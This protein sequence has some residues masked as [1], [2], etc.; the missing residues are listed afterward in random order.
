MRKMRDIYVWGLLFVYEI[1]KECTG[2]VALD[3]ILGI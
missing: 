1:S 3:G 2:C